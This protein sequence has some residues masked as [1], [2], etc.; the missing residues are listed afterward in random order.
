MF[1]AVLASVIPLK[2][3]R[4][5]SVIARFVAFVK[6]PNPEFWYVRPKDVKDSVLTV[7]RTGKLSAARL[8]PPVRLKEP[9]ISVRVLADM[10]VTLKMLLP[11]RDPVSF[12]MPSKLMAPTT[13]LVAIAIEPL[14]VE[15]PAIAVASV[16]AVR[17]VVAETE[18]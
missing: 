1:C 8:V 3:W 12:C 4:N 18:H 5:V 16:L 11:I 17:V 14:N 2:D 7:A 9:S 15:Q 6:L 10:E 13:P